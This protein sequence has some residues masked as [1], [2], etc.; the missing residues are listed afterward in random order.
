VA[1]ALALSAKLLRQFGVFGSI[2]LFQLHANPFRQCRAVSPGRNGDLQSA[3]TDHRWGDE[4]A[5]L[6]RIDDV[7]PDLVFP[8]RLAHGHIHLGSIGGTD[9]QRTA[10]DVIGAKSSRLVRDDTF[11]RE[12]SQCFAD[13][14]ADHKDPRFSFEQPVHFTSGDFSAADHEAAFPL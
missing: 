13:F 7:H 12:G 1:D 6:W 14:G 10:Q 5:G 9:D 2:P 8:C 4:V 11:R 3:T